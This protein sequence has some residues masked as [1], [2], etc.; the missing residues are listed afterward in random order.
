MRMRLPQVHNKE[1]V[2]NIF[3]INRAQVLRA[4][5]ETSE[6][7]RSGSSAAG[8]APFLHPQALWKS[9]REWNQAAFP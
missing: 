9:G 6:L 8:K 7:S 5:L 1:S 3:F 4:S 2:S